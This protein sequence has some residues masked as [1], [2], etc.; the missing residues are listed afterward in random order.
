[1]SSGAERT[2]VMRIILGRTLSICRSTIGWAYYG[3]MRLVIIAVLFAGGVWAAD[4]VTDRAAIEN[5]V[6][7]LGLSP[8]REGLYTADF[9]HAELARLGPAPVAEGG[10]I[11]VTIDGVPGT[12]VI[13]KEPMGE[14]EWFPP[15][16]H[17]SM[18]VKKIRFVT[19]E[20]AM[21]DAMAKGPVLIVL[22]KV[23]TDWK[24]ASL[25]RLAED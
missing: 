8:A 23:G 14:A 24:I 20:V 21:A 13:S 17:A 6:R 5:T 12:V 25:R 2:A 19:P 22:R 18:V 16:T 10:G 4:E 1:M 7:A 3:F 9:D 11:P 15:G